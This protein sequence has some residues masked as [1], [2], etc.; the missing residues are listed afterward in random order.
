MYLKNNLERVQKRALAI[1]HPCIEYSE[2]LS[3]AGFPTVSNYNQ[4]VWN[5]TINSTVND[6]GNLPA[7]NKQTYSFRR[8][9]RFNIRKWKTDRFR[10]TFLMSS[11]LENNLV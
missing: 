5:K 1:I 11:C 7:V 2:A 9:R 10:S 4:S 8:N 3:R 6:E